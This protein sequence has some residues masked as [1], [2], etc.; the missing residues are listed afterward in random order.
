MPVTTV[1]SNRHMSTLG[2]TQCNNCF[3]SRA[4]LFA[5]FA[6]QLSQVGNKHHVMSQRSTSQ[7][8][9][10]QGRLKIHP[11]T[12]GFSPPSLLGTYH[13]TSPGLP[14][15]YTGYIHT[16]TANILR[17]CQNLAAHCAATEPTIFA[18]H[19]TPAAFQRFNAMCTRLLVPCKFRKMPGYV[20]LF[21]TDF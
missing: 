21:P 18:L 6:Y 2:S 1:T 9:S 14:R 20:R 15:V 11:P 8:G 5:G 16:S 10:A 3:R 7:V 12:R 17:I 19:D 4:T 13:P